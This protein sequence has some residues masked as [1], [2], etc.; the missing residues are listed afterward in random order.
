MK[1]KCFALFNKDSS[2]A[3]IDVMWPG[4]GQ[5]GRGG[6]EER[7]ISR[8]SGLTQFVMLAL[9]LIAIINVVPVWHKHSLLSGPYAGGALRILHG[10][11]A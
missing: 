4:R 6:E 1:A 9:T 11:S 7:P 2:L 5:W 10:I 3:S 8:A